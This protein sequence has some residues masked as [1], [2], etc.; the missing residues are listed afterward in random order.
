MAKKDAFCKGRKFAIPKSCF[1]LFAL[2]KHEHE[3]LKRWIDMGQQ[4]KIA[5]A[6]EGEVFLINMEKLRRYEARIGGSGKGL[7]AD[8]I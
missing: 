7:K 1:I 2:P 6:S 4:P 5:I 8:R 3:K